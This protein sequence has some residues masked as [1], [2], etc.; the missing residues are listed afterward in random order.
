MICWLT[1][2][3]N[4]TVPQKAE[5]IREFRPNQSHPHV[6]N[7]GCISLLYSLSCLVSELVKN[8]SVGTQCL[9][10]YSTL[11]CDFTLK[12]K[13]YQP[14]NVMFVDGLHTQPDMGIN[15]TV[16][17]GYW[18]DYS[19]GRLRGPTITLHSRDANTLIAFLVVFVIVVGARLW[20]KSSTH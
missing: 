4:Q 13:P 17:T 8:N 2:R 1:W 10:N 7:C 16:H 15:G 19:K 6:P 12:S 3:S 18:V 14:S 11:Q 5:G 9:D 20:C